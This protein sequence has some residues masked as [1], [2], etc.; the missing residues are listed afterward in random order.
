MILSPVYHKIGMKDSAHNPIPKELISAAVSWLLDR[1]DRDNKILVHCRAGIGR[2]GSTVLAFLFARNR[3]WS[4]DYCKAYIER[5]RFI[6]PHM[7]LKETLEELY[8]R[9]EPPK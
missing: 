9:Q 6:Y 1:N 4:Y 8:P 2:A 3:L 7:G 5:R